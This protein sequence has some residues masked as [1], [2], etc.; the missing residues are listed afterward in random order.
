MPLRGCSKVVVSSALACVASGW[1]AP[2]RAQT[3]PAG[4]YQLRTVGLYGAGYEYFQRDGIRREVNAKAINSIGQV[5]GTS[6]RFD[7]SGSP[8]G[9]DLWLY[10]G[11]TSQ[12]IG[13]VGA[14]YERGSTQIY[15]VNVANQ[16]NDAGQVAGQSDRYNSQGT[17]LGSDAWLYSGGIP[18]V[19]S[20]TGNGYEY[21]YTGAG[22]GTLRGSNPLQL[23]QIGDVLGGAARYGPTGQRYGSDA[24]L[25]NGSSTLQIGLTGIGYEIPR[26]SGIERRGTPLQLNGSGQAIGVTSRY[27]SSGTVLGQD[28]W[29]YNPST[30]STQLIGFTGTGYDNTLT[31]SGGGTYRVA[32]AQQINAAGQVM[33]YTQRLPTAS[34]SGQPDPDAPQLGQDPWIYSGA[35]TNFI[36]LTGPGYE[37]TV[38]GGMYRF[39]TA[40]QLNA[41][42]KVA[43]FTARR[44]PTNLD[45]GQDAWLW[46]GTI[47]QN[48]G[49]TGATYEAGNANATNRNSSVFQMNPAGEVVGYSQRFTAT[50]APVENDPWLFD[51]SSTRQIAPTGSVI[52]RINSAGQ[53]IGRSKSGD[54]TSGWFFDDD[55]GVTT[56]LNFSFP[57]PGSQAQTN[58]VILTENGVVLGNYWKYTGGSIQGTYAFWWSLQ[59]GFHELGTLVNGDLSAQQWQFLA[60]A[61][62]SPLFTPQAIGEG[63]SPVNIVG[64][65]TMV[66]ESE[67][68]TIPV[69]HSVYLLTTIPEPSF[70]API[71]GCMLVLVGTRKRSP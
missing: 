52:N 42:G 70:G 7:S 67:Y 3:P 39:G 24:W 36:G 55:T 57:G 46:D 15:R 4:G 5:L 41:T 65:G 31:G 23:N 27:N 68:D 51:G 38:P 26:S 13:L 28:A 9:A 58:P 16:L 22:G 48:I 62:S 8:L 71:V 50:G 69:G 30:L 18:Q 47:T 59:A 32:A 61:Y 20:L 34:F 25:Y 49:L 63:G 19:I 64:R 44:S 1:F 17:S 2:A 40:Q 53:V 33:G 66:G 43:G 21:T 37:S 6:G 35:S 10:S 29:L 56:T 14:G 12:I 54:V 45:L 11:N 60:T